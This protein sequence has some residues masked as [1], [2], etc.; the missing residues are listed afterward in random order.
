MNYQPKH[1]GETSD[2]RGDEQSVVKPNDINIGDLPNSDTATDDMRGVEP[3]AVTDPEADHSK[4][5][6]GAVIAAVVIGDIDDRV[7]FGGLESFTPAPGVRA[8][9]S[10]RG[11][12]VLD[13]D[14]LGN[15][16]PRR[17][18]RTQTDSHQSQCDSPREPTRSHA[19]P[20]PRFPPVHRWKPLAP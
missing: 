15:R 14:R 9:F 16:G 19:A 7:G 10:P 4:M 8:E 17:P 12:E 20:G 3:P 6:V 2:L 1:D 11:R 13:Q 18:S 5:I